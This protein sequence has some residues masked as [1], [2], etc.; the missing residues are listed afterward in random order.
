MLIEIAGIRIAIE[1]R[2]GQMERMSKD[3]IVEE[4]GKPVDIQI[5]VSE[6][7]ID[8]F[9]KLSE[10]DLPRGAHEVTAILAKLCDELVAYDAFFLHAAVVAVDGQAFAF[11]ARSGTGKSTHIRSWLKEFGDRAQV[12]NGDKPF[13][14]KRGDALLAAGTPWC[15]KEGWQTNTQVPLKGICFL[16]RGTE[17]KIRPIEQGEI[18]ERLF[19]Q[20]R[21]P[22]DSLKM[23]KVMELLDWTMN[24]I[25]FYIL[26]CTP[27]PEAA[28]VSYQGM[29]SDE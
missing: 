25:P 6:A 3:Y 17:N 28:L 29:T 11:S 4:D 8:V 23:L 7:D 13:C 2:Y 9:E 22:E 10:E 20:L 5:S 24:H 16:E 14:F 21:L 19:S 1:N 26:E 12:V 15:G 27:D 18:L